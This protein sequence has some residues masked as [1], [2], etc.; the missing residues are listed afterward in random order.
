MQMNGRLHIIAGYK[1]HGTYLKHSYCKQP[2]KVANITEGNTGG[3]LRLMI[4]S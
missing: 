4:M 1:N 2:F 3:L